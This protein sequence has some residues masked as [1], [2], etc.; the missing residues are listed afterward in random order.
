MKFDNSLGAFD[1]IIFLL[2]IARIQKQEVAVGIFDLLGHGFDPAI[3]FS[4][5]GYSDKKNCDWFHCFPCFI[6]FL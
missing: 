4:P 2:T 6:L 1:I 5:L 3:L